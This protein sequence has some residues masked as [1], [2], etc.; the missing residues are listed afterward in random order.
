MPSAKT[1]AQDKLDPFVKV[2][3]AEGMLF[4]LVVLVRNCSDAVSVRAFLPGRKHRWTKLTHSALKTIRHLIRFGVKLLLLRLATPPPLEIAN[5]ARK[6]AAVVTREELP[7]AAERVDQDGRDLEPARDGVVV[8]AVDRFVQ[9]LQ[10]RKG[11]D[12]LGV[13]FAF[14]V[15]A[16][17]PSGG[18]LLP[19]GIAALFA[20]RLAVFPIL[21]LGLPT[22]DDCRSTPSAT[23]ISIQPSA[24]RSISH[25]L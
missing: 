7:R 24:R 8:A 21:G 10:P 25:L 4:H 12:K 23:H 11:E 14:G 15:L 2:Q 6:L 16:C 18:A 3:A 17:R 22:R 13:A 19:A 5:H 1:Y 20:A 9:V